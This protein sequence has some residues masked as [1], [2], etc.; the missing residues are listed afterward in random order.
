MATPPILVVLSNLWTA[1]LVHFQWSLA[2]GR[3]LRLSQSQTVIRNDLSSSK[4][5]RNSIWTTAFMMA[6]SLHWRLC[7]ILLVVH[8]S[9]INHQSDVSD[10][11]NIR[12]GRCRCWCP[13]IL[14]GP[15]LL[16]NPWPLP[17]SVASVRTRMESTCSLLLSISRLFRLKEECQN[18]VV[19]IEVR[20]GPIGNE[21]L[22]LHWGSLKPDTYYSDISKSIGTLPEFFSVRLLEMLNTINL[23]KKALDLWASFLR[24]WANDSRNSLIIFDV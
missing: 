18:R 20:T 9:T 16:S 6:L 15:S 1:S 5:P 12:L 3:D 23:R 10:R 11:S 17:V 2:S 13:W 7:L 4:V 8:L 14:L 22:L 21:V 19:D 24:Y